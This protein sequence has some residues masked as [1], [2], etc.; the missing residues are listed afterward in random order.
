MAG[1]GNPEDGADDVASTPD[2]V[3]DELE[4]DLGGM[5]ADELE[6]DDLEEDG[7]P[8]GF[9]VEGEDVEDVEDE[10][11][12]DEGSTVS[13]VPLAVVAEEPDDFEDVPVL[14][15]QEDEEE[16]VAARRAGEFICTRCYLVKAN[17]Q[18]VN[19]SKKVCRDCA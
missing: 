12:G 2:E 10:V 4:P 3:E 14:V 13:E 16:E 1:A 8:D 17:T 9:V 15:S 19:R 18:L 11:I 7:I 6:D 5:G